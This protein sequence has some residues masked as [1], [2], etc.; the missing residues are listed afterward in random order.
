MR[1]E[2]H[3]ADVIRLPALGDHSQ[4]FLVVPGITLFPASFA[5]RV[6]RRVHAGCAAERLD[7]QARVVGER[8]EAA[9]AARVSRLRER[10]LHE[11]RMRLFGFYDAELGLGNQRDAERREQ[12]PDLPEFSGVARRENQLHSSSARFWCCTS[13]AMPWAASASSASS[14]LRENVPP[15][16]VPCTS[17]K[18]PAPVM[19]TFMSQP[20]PESSP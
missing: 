3:Q 6:I 18:P 7:A 5:A 14:S 15:S 13:S 4:Q 12:L 10:V 11:R 8:R 16:A 20:Q 1:H 17:T 19:T 2:R 9:G